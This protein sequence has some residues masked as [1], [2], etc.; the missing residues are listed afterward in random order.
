MKA[1]ELR[2]LTPEELAQQ[3]EQARKDYF[4]LRMQKATGRL[5]KPVALRSARRE[6]ARI[7]TVL[8]ESKPAK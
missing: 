7:E 2:E 3:L 6:I 8:N 5:E 1:K 4:E